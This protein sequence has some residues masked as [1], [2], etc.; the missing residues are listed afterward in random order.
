MHQRLKWLI[1]GSRK[2]AAINVNL[3]VGTETAE[4]ACGCFKI[5]GETRPKNLFITL[6]YI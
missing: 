6:G 5:I 1:P 2:A 4:D 3:L